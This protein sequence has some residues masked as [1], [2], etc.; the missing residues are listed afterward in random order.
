LVYH[1]QLKPTTTPD[2]SPT[3]IGGEFGNCLQSKSKS[4][5]VLY[6]DLAEGGSNPQ[7]EFSTSEEVLL[8]A[9]LIHLL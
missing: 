9:V 8:D 6:K 4:S 5:E 7:D 3:L 2:L 1:K